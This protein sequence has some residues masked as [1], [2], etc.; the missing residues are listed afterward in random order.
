MD[1]GML[2]SKNSRLELLAR[3]T[4]MPI[5]VLSFWIKPVISSIDSIWIQHRNNFKNKFVHQNLLL[6]QL[7]WRVL[8]FA[9]QK[10]KNSIQNIRR[11]CLT[12]MY[13]SRQKYG[14]LV[15]KLKR[16]L[17]L[18]C[19][20]WQKSFAIEHFFLL[21]SNMLEAWHCDQFY[22]SSFKRM[23]KYLSMDIHFRARFKFVEELLRLDHWFGVAKWISVSKV[24]FFIL[25]AN[26]IKHVRPT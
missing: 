16:S 21:S 5:Q 7:T 8:L 25:I 23:E 19:I 10:F 4:V 1:E 12:R 24:Y 2:G 11:C 17:I 6:A 9:R 20:K 22:F 26:I 13:S 14:F 3:T 18:W 15:I